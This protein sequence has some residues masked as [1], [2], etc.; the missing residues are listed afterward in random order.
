MLRITANNLRII[1][2]I[3]YLNK[4]VVGHYISEPKLIKINKGKNIYIKNSTT[5][6]DGLSKTINYYRNLINEKKN[7]KTFAILIG[8]AGS[9]AFP[10]KNILKINGK[11]LFEY[12]LIEAL[13]QNR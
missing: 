10:G 9:S 2:K 13:K 6:N 11:H 3:K 8:R 4:K 5:L 1:N 12:P 7:K